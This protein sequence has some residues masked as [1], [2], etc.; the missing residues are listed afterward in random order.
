MGVG[1]V[2]HRSSTPAIP[3]PKILFIDTV[4]FTF[5]M[6]NGGNINFT[7]N[8]LYMQSI[9]LPIS[10]DF[11]SVKIAGIHGISN[12][13]NTLAGSFMV[14]IY[15]RNGATLSTVATASG[16]TSLS[17]TTT[18]NQSTYF[19]FTVAN[20]LVLAPGAYYIG[21]QK[22]STGVGSYFFKRAGPFSP[23]N[24]RP[25]FEG[26]RATATSS[27]PGV[28]YNTSAFDITGTDGIENPYIVLS[29]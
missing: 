4:P 24:A 19:D 21:I 29:S 9:Y 1:A 8:S 25:F 12:S 2:P 13:T 20:S 27:S 5:R 7:N 15:T 26:G 10:M 17:S 11:K 22:S 14:A 28:S 16:T 3:Q 6:I 23:A 18:V